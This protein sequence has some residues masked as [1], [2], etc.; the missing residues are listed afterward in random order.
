MKR[1]LLT[2]LILSVAFTACDKPEPEIPGEIKID[3]TEILLPSEGGSEVVRFNA[4]HDWTAE[5]LSAGNVTW[6]QVSPTSGK[7][8]D[9]SFTVSAQANGSEDNLS[10]IIKIT[11]KDAIK[12]IQVTQKQKDALTVTA[13]EFDVE[14][15]GGEVNIEVKAN[16]EFSYSI[17]DSAKTW[18]T[19]SQTKALKL[20][21]LVFIVKP[22]EGESREGTIT[23]SSG[24]FEEEITVTQKENPELAVNEQKARER[25]YLMKLYESNGG[26]NWKD[27]TNWGSDEPLSKW[28][29]IIT[30]EKG[31]VKAISL[32][33]NNVIGEIPE[34][35]SELK[36]LESF[37]LSYNKMTGSIP[38][39]LGQIENLDLLYL[40][41]NNFTGTIPSELGNLEKLVYLDLDNNSLSGEIP[42]SLGNLKSLYRLSL[43]NNKL[44][45]NIPSS[46]G[47]LTKMGHLYLYNN[48]LEGSIPAELGNLSQLENVVIWG[49]KLSGKVPES[50]MK[51]PW[52]EDNWH[53]ILNQDGY[54]ISEEGINIYIPEFSVKTLKGETLTHEIVKE[55]KLTVLYHFLDWCPFAE[56]FTPR[57]I[58]VYD[59]FKDLG[60]GVFSPTS[61]DGETV[62]TY[63]DKFRIPWPCTE[64]QQE[65]G[66]FVNYI[67]RT[68]TVMVYDSTGRAV[69][70]SALRDYG[71]LIDFLTEQ[72]GSPTGMDPGYVSEDYSE[73]GK[74]NVLQQAT[75]GNGI[76]LILLG[77]GYSDRLVA[78][79]TYEKTMRLAMDKFFESE[80]VKS[81]KNLFNVY[82]VTAV[83][84]NEVYTAD[85]ETALE[86]YFG[87]NMH[88]GGNDTKA[89]AY[90]RKAITEDR[91]N[92]A[93]IVVIM[94][95]TAFAGTCYMYD[96]IHN[97]AIDYYGNGTSVSYFPVGV[98]EEALAQLIKHEAVG[99]GFAKLA[100]EYVYESN[101]TISSTEVQS[102][103]NDALYGWWK[104]V[105]FTSDT[106]SVKWSHFLSD[107]R[108]K[109]EGLGVYEGGLTY[110]KG[111]YRPSEDGAMNS[112]VGPFN[113]PSREAIY[114]RIHKLAYGT[115][116]EYDYD[117]FVSYDAKNRTTSTTSAANYVMI[118]S[119]LPGP[120]V[121]TGRTW[122]EVSR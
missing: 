92:D 9:A 3:V 25:E 19:Y 78:D 55:N 5:V 34:G 39:E 97:N 24:E 101:G 7:A 66:T 84:K 63:V 121:V 38:A 77:D 45:G 76:D 102:K 91:M 108:Y 83:S 12:N 68:P 40:G 31:F 69:F 122:R 11:S 60:L 85:S 52:W 71:E 32:T 15:E 73:D 79:G 54:G 23:I 14:A 50:V 51:A 88:V 86:G 58:A 30:N 27:K 47:N 41:S 72:L 29:G 22:N 90:A 112:G 1:L 8:G 48:L 109:D 115:E 21:Q 28:F 64:N 18:I 119:E 87:G 75:D 36:Q 94:N 59:M 61:Q 96:P 49:N 57:L 99:H 62:N 20:S 114:Y 2:L 13:S 81:Y 33:N 100:D 117:D 118:P 35:L 43:F 4:S 111:V 10:A 6:C 37:N 67:D 116:W 98:N 120:P 17:S 103:K 105:D 82:A 110:P 44:T 95:S 106:T 56:I 113:A 93:V 42:S 53:L 80:P 65:T 70:N 89:M 26:E 46:I 16:I 104:N 107:A 74:V